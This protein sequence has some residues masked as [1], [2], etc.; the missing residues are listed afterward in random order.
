MLVPNGVITVPSFVAPSWQS[1]HGGAAPRSSSAATCAGKFGVAPAGVVTEAAKTSAASAASVEATRVRS[2]K[3][4]KLPQESGHASAV[5]GD[6]R[7]RHAAM[8]EVE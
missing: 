1:E 8:D 4:M 5:V 2:E 3:D 7:D 6:R